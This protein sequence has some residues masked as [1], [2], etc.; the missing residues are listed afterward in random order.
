MARRK[1]YLVVGLKN[2]FNFRFGGTF[3]ATNSASSRSRN[4]TRTST[5]E[6]MLILSLYVRLSVAMKILLSR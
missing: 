1:I 2:P 5:D 3:Q 6:A 4:G